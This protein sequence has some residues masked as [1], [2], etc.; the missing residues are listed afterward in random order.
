[1]IEPVRWLIVEGV[2]A[3]F[4]VGAL[5]LTLGVGLSLREVE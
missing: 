5:Y 2:I 1:M 3:L 4:G